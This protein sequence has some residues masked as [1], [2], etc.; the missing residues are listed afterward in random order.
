MPE[1]TLTRTV[2]QAAVIGCCSRTDKVLLA[3]LES[4]IDIG[5]TFS[6]LAL[7]TRGS[8]T[9]RGILLIT[10]AIS[11]YESAL[12]SLRQE[13]IHTVSAEFQ[14]GLSRLQVEMESYSK[15]FVACF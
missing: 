7:E 8:G 4:E 9:A 6:R 11:A 14:D 12:E 3:V 10:K 1:R 15:Q 2:P 5:F 13:S